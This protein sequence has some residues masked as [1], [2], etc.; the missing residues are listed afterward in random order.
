VPDSFGPVAWLGGQYQKFIDGAD[1][2]ID[3]NASEIARQSTAIQAGTAYTPTI[4]TPNFSDVAR[5]GPPVPVTPQDRRTQ[6]AFERAGLPSPL[7]PE[8]QAQIAKNRDTA[9][10]IRSS[11]IPDF[12]QAMAQ[13]MTAVDNVQDAAITVAVGGRMALSALAAAGDRLIPGLV[14]AALDA[15]AAA[16]GRA[17]AEAAG[18]L[19]ADAL[20]DLAAAAARGEAGAA[21]RLAATTAARDA[22]MAAAEGAAVRAALARG[23]LG[24]GTRVG[25]RL[26]PVI[27]TAM[28]IADLL[29]LLNMALAWFGAA[30][31]FAC[32]G[33]KYGVPAG[34]SAA[35]MGN[36]FARMS[37]L[38]PRKAG[39]PVPL[40]GG[41][42]KGARGSALF[43]QHGGRRARAGSIPTFGK[44]LPNFSE[45]VQMA[46]TSAD[47]I[48]Y[49]VALGS[50]MGYMGESLYGAARVAAGEKV[51]VRSPSINHELVQR[52]GPHVFGLSKGALWH[53]ELMTRAASTAWIVLL[54]PEVFGD[55]LYV[56]AWIVL[57]AGLEPLSWDWQ[58]TDWRGLLHLLPEAKYTG[59]DHRAEWVRDELERAGFNP[60]DAGP[61]PLPGL[62]LE[63]SAERLLV[64]VGPRIRDALERWLAVD[65]QD[66]QRIVI[67]YLAMQYAERVW[68]LA[69]GRADFWKWELAPAAAITEAMLLANRWPAAGDD[70]EQLMAAWRATELAMHQRGRKQLTAA[71]LDRIWEACGT[72]LIRLVP[73][74][75]GM[76]EEWLR[77]WDTESGVSVGFTVDD[78]RAR[79]EKN[80]LEQYRQLEA[81]GLDKHGLPSPGSTP[82]KRPV[83]P[84][85]AT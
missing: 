33:A 76:P 82:G 38:S 4:N 20:T 21:A 15:F 30:Y 51:Q 7:A 69:E 37:K 14:G 41:R 43:G 83:N 54:Y 31:G 81:A 63:L 22:A 6:A 57:Y 45:A 3:P 34:V 74:A 47:T 49:G 48:G 24:L 58:F 36:P 60:Q 23:A 35:L 9:E 26:L 84:S 68:I 32:G 40:P 50:L 11:A 62:P 16:A 8:V 44:S 78:I 13:V 28:L 79:A 73:N 42:A 71:E 72:P 80:L 2:L 1:R 70:P 46:Q 10:R 77:P 56:W 25:L 61:W 67:S 12:A 66:P 75:K 53:R 18:A 27:G 65:P 64:E 19:Y 85:G 5:R 39:I 55:E 29:N 17:A 52:L 59:Y